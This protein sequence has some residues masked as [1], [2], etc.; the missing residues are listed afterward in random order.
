MRD[1]ALGTGPAD[2][3]VPL[4]QHLEHP[5]AAAPLDQETAAEL[6]AYAL[7]SWSDWWASKALDWVDQG[8]H[9]AAVLAALDQTARDQRY[10]Q[11]TRHRAWRMVKS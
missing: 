6:V 4:L 11:A 10:S 9:S 7:T 8:V 2:P 1:D 5:R 3:W